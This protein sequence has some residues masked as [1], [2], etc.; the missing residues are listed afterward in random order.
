MEFRIPKNFSTVIEHLYD[1]HEDDFHDMVLNYNRQLELSIG[2]ERF[3]AAMYHF[4]IGST[5]DH[6]VK[7]V[8]LDGDHSVT[9]FINRCL[10]S[11]QPTL[12]HRL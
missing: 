11:L 3:Q 10:N 6:R 2:H 7:R 12:T 1:H 4:L 5:P 8:D 9:N